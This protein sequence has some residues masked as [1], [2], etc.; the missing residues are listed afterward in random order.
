MMLGS[1]VVGRMRARGASR[2]QAR[3]HFVKAA[4]LFAKSRSPGNAG[5]VGRKIAREAVAEADA[6][7]RRFQE[8]QAETNLTY[9]G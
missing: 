5:A 9:G 7:R 1:T 8:F 6:L 3:Q 4:Q 2:S